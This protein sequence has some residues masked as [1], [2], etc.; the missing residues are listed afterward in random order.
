MR[1]HGAREKW[2]EMAAMTEM[3]KIDVI[4]LCVAITTLAFQLLFRSWSKDDFSDQLF[5]F[6]VIGGI[7]G[8]L[9]TFFLRWRK[10][11]WKF[12]LRATAKTVLDCASKAALLGIL[13]GTIQFMY[14]D[15]GDK[16]LRV[17]L[18]CFLSFFLIYLTF[19]IST[20]LNKAGDS[21]DH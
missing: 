10:M 3:R 9:V 8:A 16:L 1:K 15:P 4:G 6:I 2:G 20:F 11:S 14:N 17:Y 7:L 21:R 19:E 5:E 13:A 12:D 18:L